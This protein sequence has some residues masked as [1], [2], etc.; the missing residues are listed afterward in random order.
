MEAALTATDQ[1]LVAVM[2]MALMAMKFSYAQLNIANSDRMG[3][4]PAGRALCAV[5][6]A[7]RPL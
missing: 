2:A 1:T 6:V 3:Q 7:P 4:G 5:L